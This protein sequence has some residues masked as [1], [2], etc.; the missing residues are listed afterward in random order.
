MIVVESKVVNLQQRNQIMSI[1]SNRIFGGDTKLEARFKNIISFSSD[2]RTMLVHMTNQCN[3]RCQACWFFAEHFDQRT[4]EIRE[5]ARWDA[6]AQQQAERGATVGLLIGG[7]P[8][9]YPSRI[10][11]IRQHIPYI[12]VST[13]G[14]IP[15]SQVDFPDTTIALTLFGGYQSDDGYR[16]IR[17][18]GQRF[19]GLFSKV[20]KN[21]YNDPRAGFVYAVTYQA[22]DEIEETVKRIQDNGQRVLFNFY[23][24]FSHHKVETEDQEMILLDKT[25]TVKN[26]FPDTVSSTPY[27]LETMFVG[28]THWA[29]FSY[30][31]CPSISSDYKG[32]QS[33][34]ANGHPTLPGF[35]AYTADH[36]PVLCCSG[37]VCKTCRDSQAITSWVLCNMRKYMK[38]PELMQLWIETA[39]AYWS[40]FIWS[41]WHPCYQNIRSSHEVNLLKQY[42]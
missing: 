32:A 19:S 42:A 22:I 14:E 20:L 17:S 8:T 41:P 11:A 10:A 12:T 4:Q 24:D 38:R 1:Q 23:R 27:M 9:L 29:K 21:Y 25:L 15:L 2:K 37:G 35:N 34:L 33:R 40:Q 39:E 30:N 3:L 36:A 6:F 26:R 28:R 5:I 7:E 18:N 13:N 16:A 31:T